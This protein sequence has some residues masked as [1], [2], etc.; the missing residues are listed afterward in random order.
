MS[1]LNP[2]VQKALDELLSTIE[3]SEEYIEY[4]RMKLKI[5][6]DDELY[7]QVKRAQDIRGILHTINENETG[8]EYAERIADE[9]EN[10]CENT[11]VYEYLRAEV[12]MGEMVREILGG[13]VET[14]ELA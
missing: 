12:M 2:K 13:I 5:D 7:S 14:T 3:N 1:R 6:N 9:Y 11:F 10:L 8:S 4:K